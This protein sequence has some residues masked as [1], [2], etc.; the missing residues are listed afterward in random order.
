MR[1]EACLGFAECCG[2][3]FGDEF[4]S[5]G[6]WMDLVREQR[7][8]IGQRGVEID[9]RGVEFFCHCCECWDYLGLH[10]GLIDS[11]AGFVHGDGKT[12]MDDRF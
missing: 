1:V 5:G 7:G 8:F 3:G 9:D 12:D 2:D 11:P 4:R 10:D 6:I